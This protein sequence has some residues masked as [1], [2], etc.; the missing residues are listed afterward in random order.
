MVDVFGSSPDSAMRRCARR[1]RAGYVGAWFSAHSPERAAAVRAGFI[2]VPGMNPLTLMARPLREL[3][4]D[5][6][7]FDEWDL[8]ISDLELL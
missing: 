1:S 5:V 4:I 7:K 2:P 3:D 6:T 8:S